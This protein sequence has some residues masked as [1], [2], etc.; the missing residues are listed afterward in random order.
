MWPRPTLGLYG[1]APDHYE[2]LL[3]ILSGEGCVR[4]GQKPAGDTGEGEVITVEP[5][6]ESDLDRDEIETLERV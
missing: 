2:C 4:I 5:P 1:P 3:G 6:G